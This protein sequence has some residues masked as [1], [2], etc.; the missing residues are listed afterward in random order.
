MGSVWLA[1]DSRL[2]RQ[3]A[4]KTLLAPGTDDAPARARLMREARAAAA[5]NHPHIATVYDV[6]ES[7]G[8][9]VIVFEHV[10]GETLAARLNRGP[11]PAPEA[12]EIACQIAKALT[13]AHAHGI[14]HRDLKPANVI[15]TAGDQVKVLD[16]GIARQL[17][18][19]STLTG[20]GA[21]ASGMGFVGTPAYAAPEQMV[22][23]AVD[24]RADLYALGVVLFE[25]ISGRRP[26]PGGDPV[27][28][29]S[30]KLSEDAPPLKSTGALIPRE[31]ERLVAS[32]L[33]RDRSQRPDSAVT[34][35]AQLRAIY[36]TPTTGL[37]T[38]EPPSRTIAAILAAVLLV[39]AVAGYG[40]W[41]ARRMTEGATAANATPPVVAV[42]PLD[43]ISGDT[44]RDF[45]SAGISESLIAG[46]AGSP[47]LTVLSRAAV[48]E[49]RNRVPE[50]AALAKDLGATYLVQGGV[51]QSGD[52]LRVT[53]SLLR[54]DRTIAWANSFD[55][56]LSRIF[57]LQT[58]MSLALGEAMSVRVGDGHATAQRRPTDTPEALSE[59]WKGRAYLD[60]R[61]V[62][63]NLEAAASSFSEAIRLDPKFALAHAALGETYWLQ[64]AESREPVWMQ[65]SADEGTTALRLDSQQ[66]EVRLALAITLIGS[67][68]LDEG[69]EELRKALAIRPTYDDARRRLGSA[70][71]RQGKIDEAIDEFQKAIAL[72]PNFW[73]NY[74]DLGV[75][76]YNAARYQEAAKA[77][78]RLVELQPD[79][80]QGFQQLGTI[81]QTLGD[82]GRALENYRKSIAVRPSW[83]AYNNLGALYHTGGQ[84]EKAIEAYQQ[85]IALRPNIAAGFRNVGDALTRLG[86]PEEARRAYLSA[87][88]KGEAELAVNPTNARTLATV[89]VYLAKAGEASRAANSIAKALALAPDD[90]QVVY[91]AA[92]AHILLGRR[93]SGLQYLERAVASGYSRAAVAQEED[94][95]GI[96]SS[97]RFRQ[98]TETPER[99]K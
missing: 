68:K 86:R 14:V 41:E 97:V 29:A 12:V 38:A 16:F 5:L 17:S 44:S 58:R 46:L 62:K 99:E 66:P 47:A 82:P 42:L 8:Q 81:Y 6:L 9:V 55:G 3:V 79:N 33:A 19:G 98:L 39:A 10:E 31:L 70:L 15:V 95:D 73:G 92:V 11:L 34:A 50:L 45:L 87:V 80:H 1:E 30:S 88:E 78:E 52:Q 83:G 71:A 69:I 65:R 2:H 26:F 67:G 7:D 4:L 36:G 53:L 13:V 64:Y 84:Y 35:L 21:T 75:A 94:F 61:D 51:Q 91:R 93:E 96:R 48:L 59:Y 24:E 37:M 18:T 49:A 20:G 28:L 60:R 40:V 43:N 77:F 56:A 89:S 85:G 27:E 90:V 76:L 23:S 57:E 25:M 72:R 32:L 63:G 54:P 74:N 22:S